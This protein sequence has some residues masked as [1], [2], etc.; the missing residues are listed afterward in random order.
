MES[1]QEVLR[2]RGKKY[3]EFSTHAKIT[4]L[5][6]GVV[7]QEQGY[8]R[9]NNSQREA[10]DMIMHKIG[11][12]INGDPNYVDSWVDIAGYAQL[13]TNELKADEEFNAVLGQS[14]QELTK[15]AKEHQK[16]LNDIKRYR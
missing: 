9:L 4:Q 8:S 3:G 5:L 6:K 14:Q 11:R 2:E 1:I 12:I 15:A 10:I 16:V 7:E 13:V